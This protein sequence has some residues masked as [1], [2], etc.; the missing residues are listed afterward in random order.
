MG[1]KL[2]MTSQKALL[3]GMSCYDIAVSFATFLSTWP[4]PVGTPGVFG[5]VGN[6]ATCVAQGFFIQA[7]L[8]VP[9]YN[10]SLSFYYLFVIKYG[11]REETI[12]KRFIPWVHAL[13]FLYPVITGAV[14]S[15]MN[16]YVPANLWCH[17][18]ISD[19][20]SAQA[21]TIIRFALFYGPLWLLIIL[22]S[23][24]MLMV[25]FAVLKSENKTL[26]YRQPQFT[27]ASNTPNGKSNTSVPD[28]GTLVD[29]NAEGHVVTEKTVS[30]SERQGTSDDKTAAQSDIEQPPEHHTQG[31]VNDT[32]TSPS[33][34]NGVARRTS[35]SAVTSPETETIQSSPPSRNKGSQNG[36]SR[37][38]MT[39]GSAKVPAFLYEQGHE[40]SRDVFFQSLLFF[41][42]F[43]FTYIFPTI[44]RSVQAATNQAIFPLMFLEAFFYPLEGTNPFLRCL[45]LC[46]A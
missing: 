13:A 25:F 11:A 34:G 23:V 31:S 38:R 17:T 3:L 26:K 14:C 33:D 15:A 35:A 46:I 27:F 32:P 18:A 30:I 19:V 6:N 10:A 20:D 4:M 9:I 2:E 42:A 41:L 7:G 37:I 22:S 28:P 29:S 8:A 21:P 40:K 1:R 45:S 16:L 39:L 24:A 5:A 36:K 12:R 44:N 43:F